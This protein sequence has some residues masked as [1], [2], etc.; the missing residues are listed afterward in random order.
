[1]SCH[2]HLYIRLISNPII[3]HYNPYSTF[4][5]ENIFCNSWSFNFVFFD[6]KCKAIN[7]DDNNNDLTSNREEEKPQLVENKQSEE[8]LPIGAEAMAISPQHSRNMG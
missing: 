4:F 8:Q 1:M 5:N 2:C 3:L 6:I 7:N